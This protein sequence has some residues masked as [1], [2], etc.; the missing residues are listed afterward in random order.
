[1][2]GAY[3]S[4]I[5]GL[6]AIAALAVLG[7]HAFPNL[8]PGGFVGVDIFFVI[9]GFLITRLIGKELH[10]ATFSLFDFYARRARR[11]FPALV[12]VLIGCLGVG[13]LV[14][15]PDEL[16]SLGKDIGV[17][18]AFITNFTLLQEVGYFD[19]TAELKPFLH[20]WSLGIEEQFYLVWPVLMAL[21]WRVSRRGAV[22]ALVVSCSILAISFALNV[23]LTATN[24]AAAFYL[25]LTRFWEL[26][27]GCVLGLDL[28]NRQRR[29][30]GEPPQPALD[31][32]GSVMRDR[33]AWIGAIML[34]LAFVGLERQNAYPGWRAAWPALAALLLIWAGQAA[35][36]N[37]RVLSQPVLVY[38]GLISYPLYLWHWPILAFERIVRI[39]EPTVIAKIAG[40]ALAFALAALTYKF[41]EKPIRFG[42][43]R[44]FKSLSALTALALAGCLGLLIH[45]QDGVRSWIPN[46]IV[47]TAAADFRNAA[48]EA[49]RA[50][51][52]LLPGDQESWGFAAECDGTGG[53]NARRII[54][55][56]DSHA[57][58]LFPGL[59]DLE[60]RGGA[61]RVAQYSAA[62]CPPIL[63]FSSSVRKLCASVNDFVVGRI[64]MLR[65]EIVI[66]AA[67]WELYQSGSWGEIT[68]AAIRATVTRLKSMGVGRVVGIGEF[69]V[70][71]SSA[72]KVRLRLSRTAA[73]DVFGYQGG[74]AAPPV[75]N[76]TFL[77]DGALDV[78]RKIG[79]AFES[80]GAT[81]ISP[82]ASLC[83]EEGCLLVV[84]DTDEL[85]MW[86]T[87]HLSKAG[88][89]YFVR[90]HATALG[91]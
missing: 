26:M 76:K 36:I 79:P 88:S 39:K 24:P 82:A 60:Q 61:I 23:Y 16:R 57:A 84:P 83:N 63:R 10:Q 22:A 4:D 86:D 20:L 8:V 44:R 2:K 69:P 33:G 41:V 78:D 40:L 35:W 64:E 13:W 28:S 1:V 37:R 46:S 9:S 70:W 27:L 74:A 31:R 54:L 25:P 67:R 48:E 56:G 72:Q 62:A 50:G 32:A 19:T 65:P 87:N 6:R 38:I 51:T 47:N 18:A 85:L 77:E 52:C 11:I 59:H 42:P 5:D 53:N 55:W 17:G 75:R 7:F 34:F 73:I 45:A 30:V 91:G 58:H 14:L 89:I 81:F 68:E 21:A 71:E 43:A 3:R 29:F 90:S 49:Y 15:L 80:A 12:V 66:M